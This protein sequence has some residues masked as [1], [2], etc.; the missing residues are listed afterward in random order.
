MAD[1]VSLAT[2][3][4]RARERKRWSQQQLAD[5]VGKS[6]RAVNDWENGRSSPKNAIGA[7]EHVLGVRFN[8]E[9]APIVSPRLR[10]VIHEELSGEEA[11]RVLGILE[12]TLVS[13]PG[14]AGEQVPRPG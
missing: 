13:P 6:V 2:K 11:A 9:E 3:I 1:D 7:L 4:R 10:K 12:G 8:G 14:E 5:A